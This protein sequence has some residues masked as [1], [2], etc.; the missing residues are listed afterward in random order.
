MAKVTSV[1][2]IIETTS[3]AFEGDKWSME[4]NYVLDQAKAIDGLR[5]LDSNGEDV[6]VVRIE[7]E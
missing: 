2:V 6:G 3:E 4:Y 5:L 7:T 1:T